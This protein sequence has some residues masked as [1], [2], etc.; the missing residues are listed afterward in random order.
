MPGGATYIKNGQIQWRQFGNGPLPV[1]AFHGYG[2]SGEAYSLLMAQGFDQFTCY[3]VDL[4]HHGGSS[5]DDEDFGVNEL[6]ALVA[7][8]R[9]QHASA[10]RFTLVGFSLGA[11]LALKVYEK[12][13]PDIDRLI[14]LAPDGMKVNFWYWLA[15]QTMIG[16]RLFAFTMKE[17][18]WFFT[19]LKGLHKIGAVNPS[20]F[21][22]VHRAIDDPD[23]RRL[24]YLRWTSFRQIKPSLS[25][26][27]KRIV[28]EQTPVRLVY[29][30]HDRIILPARGRR[31]AKGMEKFVHVEEIDAGHQ[32]LH[33]RHVDIIRRLFID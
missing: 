11:R 28:A 22:F 14:L 10:D 5:W 12:L 9:A 7:A 26:I 23:A 27:R 3:A 20:I 30:R 15:T 29:G 24:L 4:P 25:S 32:V 17:P 21:K 19:L 1:V 16:N 13:A 18:G 31:F 2:E 33:P 6:L 8:I